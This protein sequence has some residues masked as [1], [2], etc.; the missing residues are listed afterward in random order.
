MGEEEEG[1]P[2]PPLDAGALLAARTA[3]LE[4]SHVRSIVYNQAGV[5][6]SVC[7]CINLLL[8]GPSFLPFHVW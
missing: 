1:L 5:F 2:S 7:T 4:M 3:S 6:A 8:C